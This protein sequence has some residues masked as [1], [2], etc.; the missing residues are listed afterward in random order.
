[1][2]TTEYPQSVWYSNMDHQ[3]SLFARIY[4]DAAAII[5]DRGYQPMPE[6]LRFEIAAD[7]ESV[8]SAIDA[9]CLNILLHDGEHAAGSVPVREAEILSEIAHER[10]A[11]FLLM[12]GRRSYPR[13]ITDLVYSWDR[14]SFRVYAGSKHRYHTADE[15]VAMLEQAARCMQA[16]PRQ[17]IW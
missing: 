2:T 8:S 13:D 12:V 3:P 1:M 4:S 5:G 14:D 15:A 16:I 17:D 6:G 10:L 9:A 11:G 7:G